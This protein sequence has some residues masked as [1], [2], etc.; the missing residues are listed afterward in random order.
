MNPTEGLFMIGVT[1][2]NGKTSVTQWIAQAFASLGRRCALVGTLGNGFPGALVPG[3]NTT[4]GAHVLREL[5]P[6]F[7]RQGAQACAMEVSSI[8]LH[9]GRVA[10]IRFDV[11]AFTNLTRDHL[12][13]HGTMAAY[14]AEKAKLFRMPGLRGAVIN[15][16]D[17]FGRA[18]AA[19]LPAGVTLLG[20]TLESA[21]DLDPG[22]RHDSPHLRA[23][24]I[25]MS[26]AGVRFR[27]RDVE[28]AV[29][30][31][32]RFNIA[33]LLAVIGVLQL[34]GVALADCARALAHVVPPPG[35]LQP[36]GGAGQPLVVVDYAHT[37][38][39]LE[40]A[41]LT[42]RETATARGGRLLCVFGCGGERDPGKRPLMGAVAERRADAV[43]LTSDNPRGEDP[44]AILDAIRAGMRALPAI[45]PDRAV[46]IT[47]AVAAADTA[48]VVLV[49]GKGHE[50]YQE[51][52]G[53]RR[54]FS[55]LETA[56]V[57]L[58]KRRC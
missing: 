51:I 11:A 8:G 48:D 3:P 4:P 49:A 2:T 39:A 15:L 54:P 32:G 23:E 41:L 30:V 46:A 56:R 7:R 45:E 43:V 50:P 6:D 35:R 52:A 34:G 38:D 29:P 55:D 20:Y 24:D 13:Y 10:G 5:L 18:L 40:Q 22:D 47:A 42:L 53:E 28:F 36:L 25:V 31:V 57:A 21:P 17:A 1:G 44:L 16:D 26:T 37:P 58:E 12:E 33:N 9:Q 14:A 19:S 27:V